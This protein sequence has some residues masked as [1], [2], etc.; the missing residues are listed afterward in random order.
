MYYSHASMIIGILLQ[1]SQLNHSPIYFFF[2]IFPQI[3]TTLLHSSTRFVIQSTVAILVIL[4]REKKWPNKTCCMQGRHAYS[5]E[6]SVQNRHCC[7][8]NASVHKFSTVCLI[9]VPV[10]LREQR[11]SNQCIRK[12]MRLHRAFWMPCRARG[13]TTHAETM[14][15]MLQQ[16]CTKSHT[17]CCHEIMGTGL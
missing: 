5:R 8:K 15:V 6:A 17:H 9:H 4:P 12:Q 16:A 14:V 13:R 11:V 7:I 3:T 2:P 10:L 1:A